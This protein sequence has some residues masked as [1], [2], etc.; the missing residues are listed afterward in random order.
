[1]KKLVPIILLILI[2]SNL[3]ISLAGEEKVC[4][5]YICKAK[6]NSICKSGMEFIEKSECKSDEFGCLLRFD[7][8]CEVKIIPN[9]ICVEKGKVSKGFVQVKWIKVPFRICP[10]GIFGSKPCE[11]P[12]IVSVVKQITDFIVFNLAPS[13]AVLLVI[14]GGFMYLLTPINVEEYIKKGHTYIKYAILGYVLLL[15]TNLIFRAI[16]SLF[17]GP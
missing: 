8:V 9:E 10:P 17:G 3:E 6:D 16:S 4:C 5:I 14:I 11:Y 7:E 1:M 12:D 2:V 13:I 15:L